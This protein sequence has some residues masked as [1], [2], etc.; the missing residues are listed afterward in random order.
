MNRKSWPALVVGL[1]AFAVYANV[2][3]NSFLYGDD[4]TL[5]LRNAFLRDWR[6]LPDLLA[7]HTLAGVGLASRFYRPV[8]MV[9]YSL[10]VHAFGL[11]AWPLQLLNLSLHAAGAVLAY[12]LILDL[13]GLS[14]EAAAALA[15]LW[16][17]H[18]I[19]VEAVANINGT[20]DPLSV[21][22][23][24]AAL[25][26]Y[27]RSR[28]GPAVGMFAL[29]LGSK[30][31]A[32]VL[33]PILLVHDTLLGRPLEWRRH[34]PFWAA[35]AA[36]F[37]LR[38]RV[39]SAAGAMDF[40]DKPNLFTEHFSYRVYTL[41]VVLGEGLKLLLWP[42]GLHPERA[43]PVFVSPWSAPVLVSAAVLGAMALGA[44]AARRALPV[45]AFGVAWFFFAYFPMS[46]LVAK[47][48]S[49]FWEH[50]LYAPSLGLILA[51]AAPAARLEARLQLRAAA[52]CLPL[53]LL[54]G[55]RTWAQ[56]RVWK[57]P[58]VFSRTILIHE[59]GSA[60]TW[61]NYAMAL[62]DRSRHGEAIEAY[63]RAI[64]ISDEYPQSHHNLANAFLQEG[65]VAEAE[66]E[67]HRALAMDP[68][69][70]FSH[71]A[72]AQ[73]LLKRGDRKGALRELQE[74]LRIYPHMPQVAELARR[75]EGGT[76]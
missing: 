68:R 42:S 41:S 8:Q 30:E 69:F 50:W 64:A 63:R 71:V 59:P 70:Y 16:A 24:L 23:L 18:P 2:F 57:D 31:W 12:R 15:L 56:N 7:Q 72:L 10:L 6:H 53:L 21:A 43:V 28:M 55:S 66:T 34:L 20:A 17:L 67:L 37:L 35:L 3:Q 25:L 65:R 73:I 19:H 32:L 27:R 11:Q 48:N 40:Y 13:T 47:I 1:A 4:E 62:T 14:S 22:C 9:L 49:L 39:L 36:F 74:A 60:K 76:P 5:I 45:F 29:A 26:L 33:P 61:N 75:L 52:A 46:N 44:L 54:L 58:E 38:S 51:L